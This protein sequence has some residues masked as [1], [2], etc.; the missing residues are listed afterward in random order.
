VV[1]FTAYWRKYF[2]FSITEVN[3]G[4]RNKEQA[5]LGRRWW[6]WQQVRKAELRRG[7]GCGASLMLAVSTSSLHL[8]PQRCRNLYLLR[9]IP[10]AFFS[11]SETTA[12]AM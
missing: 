8:L 4:R 7:G 10:N 12:V 11:V 6:G 3:I 2:F 9:E 5:V 1:G